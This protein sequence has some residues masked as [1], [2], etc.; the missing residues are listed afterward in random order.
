MADWWE[1]ISDVRESG[2]QFGRVRVL[3]EPPSDYQRYELEVLTPPAVDAGEDIRLLPGARARELRL[4]ERDFWLFDDARVAVMHFGADGVH[5]AELL[6]DPAA[7]APFRAAR[8]RAWDASIPY[9]EWA[10]NAP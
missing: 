6:D 3:Y 8:A 1:W 10:A 5:G 2:R 4:P 7:V 9:R